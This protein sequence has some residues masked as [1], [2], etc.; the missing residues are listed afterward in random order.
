M[1]KPAPDAYLVALSRLALRPEECLA[2]EDS[3]NGLISARAAG[4]AA[5]VTPSLYTRHE[6]FEG[7]AAV[8]PDLSSFELTA[9]GFAAAAPPV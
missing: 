2:F 6:T 1:K 4:L 8:L 9:D 5:V 7:A 3:L